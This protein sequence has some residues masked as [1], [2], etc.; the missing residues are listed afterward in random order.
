[1]GAS[2]NRPGRPSFRKPKGASG[3]R[4]AVRKRFYRWRTSPPCGRW[5][6]NRNEIKLLLTDLVMPDGMSGIEL[7]QRLLREAPDLKVI[8]TS[9][10]SPD[11]AGGGV[12]LKEGVDFLPKPFERQRLA[13]PCVSVWMRAD[14]CLTTSPNSRCRPISAS[15]GRCAFARA[16]SRKPSRPASP[17]C[18]RPRRSCPAWNRPRSGSPH[19]CPP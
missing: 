1:M 6:E 18:P 3:W 16:A 7:S 14:G 11:I 4:Q 5:K 13:R 2:A 8:H 9:G 10:Y 19:C 17:R 12:S 15:R